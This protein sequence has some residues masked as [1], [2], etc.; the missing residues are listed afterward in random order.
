MDSALVQC[1]DDVSV[2]VRADDTDILL[3]TRKL[4]L[5]QTSH[6]CS[7]N[8]EGEKESQPH[9][10]LLL[11][12]QKPLQNHLKSSAS[13]LFPI[14]VLSSHPLLAEREPRISEG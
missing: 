2:D 14:T 4:L 3:A 5:L 13:M 9:L 11:G 7:R 10:S 12:K 1:V 6:L 8:E